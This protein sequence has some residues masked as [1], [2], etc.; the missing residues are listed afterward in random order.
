MARDNPTS[1]PPGARVECERCDTSIDG[2]RAGA[3][4]YQRPVDTDGDV[5]VDTRETM[6]LCVTC[7]GKLHEFVNDEG[8]DELRYFA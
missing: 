6:H 7:R 1:V 2:S 3:V 4:A 8:S 5:Q